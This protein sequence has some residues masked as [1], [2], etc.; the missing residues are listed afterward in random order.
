MRGVRTIAAVGGALLVSLT[1]A[2]RARGQEIQMSAPVVPGRGLRPFDSTATVATEAMRRELTRVQKAEA[3][4]Y[5]TNHRY[6]ADVADLDL[7]IANGTVVTIDSADDRSYHAVATNPD[8]P[9]A[10]IELVALAPPRGM[11][12]G[13][14]RRRA[15]ADST[16]AD[17]TQADGTETA[18]DEGDQAH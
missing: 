1:G 11:I 18:V 14:G 3:D 6:T 7:A 2:T 12:A 8:V 15:P 16:G 5:A 17:S 4:Y 9:G 13:R 10:E